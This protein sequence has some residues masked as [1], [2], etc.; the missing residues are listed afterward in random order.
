MKPRNFSERTTFEMDPESSCEDCNFMGLSPNNTVSDFVAE[1]YDAMYRDI[2]GNETMDRALGSFDRHELFKVMS[3]I[4]LQ[5]GNY[6]IY[7]Q[8]AKV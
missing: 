6:K 4:F 7:E 8:L 1:L 5:D 2:L 3:R